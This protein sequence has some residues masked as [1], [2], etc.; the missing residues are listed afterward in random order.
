ME[1][2]R[3][4]H[5]LSQLGSSL[6]SVENLLNAKLFFRTCMYSG[7]EKDEYVT[8]RIKMYERQKIKSSST[9]IPDESSADQ[10]LKRSDLQALV[11]YR[12]LEQNIDY[13][14]IE[15]RG[16][17]STPDGLY[18]TWF[19]CTQFP[20][21]LSVQE[22]TKSCDSKRTGRFLYSFLNSVAPI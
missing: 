4:Y 17:E 15:N 7:I 2:L 21:S 19:T 20:E 10:H 5:L 13:P 1:K 12:C 14:H 6:C 9:L 16:W 22:S 3:K 11:W 8:T 18:S